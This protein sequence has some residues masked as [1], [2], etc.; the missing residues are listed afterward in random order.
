[1]LHGSAPGRSVGV[2]HHQLAVAAVSLHPT[3]V[4][5]WIASKTCITWTPY[6]HVTR[7]A[8]A[9]TA[10]MHEHSHWARPE[11]S[12]SLC[13]SDRMGKQKGRYLVQ[14]GDLLVKGGAEGLLQVDEL[15]QINPSGRLTECE[16][17]K[18]CNTASAGAG[19]GSNAPLDQSWLSSLADPRFLRTSL[20][21]RSTMTDAKIGTLCTKRFYRDKAEAHPSHD[22]RRTLYFCCF[23][24]GASPVGRRYTITARWK[25]L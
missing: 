17:S 1:M 2:V 4:F 6:A 3:P 19:T 8:C 9:L 24:I 18:V 12:E 13:K 25:Q 7:D 11:K 23:R 21:P 16:K 14:D 22:S 20:R 15:Q 5:A 10:Q